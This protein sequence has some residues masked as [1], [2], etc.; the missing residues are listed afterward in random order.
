MYFSINIVYIFEEHI[1]CF[2]TM[3]EPST[4]SADSSGPMTNQNLQDH[5]NLPNL[6]R[7]VGM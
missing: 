6:V 4:S 1:F 7:M 2:L 5:N 3:D